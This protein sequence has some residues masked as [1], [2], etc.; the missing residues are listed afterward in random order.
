[1]FRFRFILILI[2]SLCLLTIQKG[3]SQNPIRLR[4]VLGTGG[5]SRTVLSQN[6]YYL[7]Q[8]SIGQSSIIG[9]DHA[10]EYSIRQG[11][12][13]PPEKLIG[14]SSPNYQ[15]LLTEVFPNPFTADIS[16]VFK[17]KIPGLV[18][19][20]IYDLFGRK[21]LNYTFIKPQELVLNCSDLT[22]GLYIIRVN[23]DKKHFITK[24]IKE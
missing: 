21:I 2:L 17:E 4:S 23:T 3:K 9:L 18:Y 19:I 11:F 13:Q 8:Q 24:L 14:I 12:I 5:S 15:M 6:N 22:T 20:S 10:H 16:I 1:M 7:I